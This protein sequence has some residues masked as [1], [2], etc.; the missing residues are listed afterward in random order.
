MKSSFRYRQGAAHSCSS[1]RRDSVSDNSAVVPNS[2]SKAC[3]W[4]GAALRSWAAPQRGDLGDS[5]TAAEPVHLDAARSA[6][7]RDAARARELTDE[8]TETT[9]ASCHRNWAVRHRMKILARAWGVA[10]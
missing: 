9:G 1:D 3:C 6:E 5:P 2:A 7:S 4:K 8:A 10:R